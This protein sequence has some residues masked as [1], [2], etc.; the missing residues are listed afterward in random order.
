MDPVAHKQRG[1]TVSLSTTKVPFPAQLQSE[2]EIRRRKREIR[3]DEEEGEA[4]EKTEYG[5][6]KGN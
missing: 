4:E 6:T 3:G 1:F 2:R 5:A